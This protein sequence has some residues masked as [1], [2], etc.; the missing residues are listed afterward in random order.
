MLTPISQF[1]QAWA[2]LLVAAL[3]I[4]YPTLARADTN[5]SVA[6]EFDYNDAFLA[7]DRDHAIG[8]A[9]RLHFISTVTVNGIIMAY[10]VK[11]KGESFATGLATSADGINWT[12]QGIVLDN[13]PAGSND[14]RIASFPGIAYADG[15]FYLVYEAAGHDNAGDVALAT[16]TDG[17]K[18]TK[19][20]RI[21]EHNTH[22]WERVNIGTPSLVLDNGVWY[23]YYH[24]FDG[25][26]VR[27]GYASGTDLTKLTKSIA[28]PVLDTGLSGTWDAGTVGKRDIIKQGNSYY[29][30]YEGST[31]KPFDTA[32]WSTGLAAA[33][34]PAGPWTKFQQN[35]VLP[36]SNGF[37]NDGPAFVNVGGQTWVYY[38]F[39][40]GTRRAA[41]TAVPQHVWQ[42]ETLPYHLIGR[43]DGSGWSANVNDGSGFLSYGPYTSDIRAGQ[44]VGVVSLAI[45][46]N[47]ADNL[48]VATI[49]VYDAT[50]ATVIA[51]RTIHRRE[52]VA[53]SNYE[54]FGIPFTLEAD[55]QGHLLEIRTQIGGSAYL[56]ED[57]QAFS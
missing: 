45:D 48:P 1:R 22:G 17:R 27:V 29:M 31:D 52:F 19:I 54:K 21:L 25:H 2:I 23:L 7:P 40:G 9:F 36:S 55:Q 35:P 13:G 39:G 53:N 28:N 34:S 4:F 11:N 32:R 14:D 15:I 49:D 37:G 26:D 56:N 43:P 3:L 47:T 10:F 8:D 20:G 41:F 46:N 5:P 44:H 42:T 50:A 12:D 51:Q 24:G 18:F 6:D 38:R 57:W 30:V 16:S 33:P